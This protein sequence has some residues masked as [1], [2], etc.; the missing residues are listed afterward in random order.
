MHLESLQ[1]VLPGYSHLPSY[2]S[3]QKG[4][5]SMVCVVEKLLAAGAQPNH[6]D[7]ARKFV[8]SMTL[9]HYC[10]FWFCLNIA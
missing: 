3:Y 2:N 5:I 4:P 7:N 10:R 9:K 1:N 6:Q 8:I